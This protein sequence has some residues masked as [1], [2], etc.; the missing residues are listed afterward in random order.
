VSFSINSDD[1]CLLRKTLID[2]YIMASDVLG[3]NYKQI[4]Q[5]VSTKLCTIAS[6]WSS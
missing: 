1:P 3:L 4:K 5:S 6:Y 2:N